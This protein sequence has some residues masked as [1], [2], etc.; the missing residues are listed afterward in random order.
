M[1][2][3]EQQKISSNWRQNKIVHRM[4]SD[5]FEIMIILVLPPFYDKYLEFHYVLTIIQIQVYIMFLNNVFRKIPEH[6][7]FS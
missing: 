2:S 3:R 4:G 7:G 6:N 5:I 1:T